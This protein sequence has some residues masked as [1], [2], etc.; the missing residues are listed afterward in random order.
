MG[1]T[2]FVLAGGGSF[3]ALQVGMLH[4]LLE[5][6]LAPD[7]IVGAS[8]GAINGAY[9]AGSPTPA[10][11][12]NLSRLWLQVRRSDIF[13]VGILSAARFFLR[14]DFLM[15]ADG[16]RALIERHLPYARLEQA[17]V[18]VHIIA[19]DFLTGE[20][21][22]LSQGPAA[23]AILASSA[24]PVA[25]APVEIDG[26]YLVDG[27]VTSNTPVSIAARL[28]ATRI[29]VLPTGFACA[30]EQPPH[31]AIANALH[32]LTL[33]IARQLV[34]ELESLDDSIEFAVVPTP[35]PRKGSPY[36]FTNAAAMIQTGLVI[37]RQWIEDGGLEN[38]SIPGSLRAH[39]HHP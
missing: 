28:G 33:L 17:S 19:T 12:E 25:F 37:C 39:G 11:I 22:V 21:V 30:L 18:P 16:L 3:G 29:I 15:T 31:G 7:L 13:G 26:R 9:L 5:H 8:V 23:D 6:G 2:A 20:A 34:A 32:A 1:K 27:A 24:I 14:R 4:A 38:R 10:G 36:D 35:C